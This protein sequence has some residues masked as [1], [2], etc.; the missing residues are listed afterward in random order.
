MCDP[1]GSILFVSDLYCGS[2]SDNDICVKSGFFE[3]LESLMQRGYLHPGDSIM[4]DKGF[5]I[6][7]KLAEIGLK[8][9]IPPFATSAHSMSAA[10]VTLTRKIAAHRIHV[11]RAIN[12]IKCFKLF[13][14]KIPVSLLH[15]I[16]EYWVCAS[17][18]TN[19]QDT[20]VKQP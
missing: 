7:D 19:F 10:N 8:L 11:E 2:I 17:L 12:Q 13:S 1:R 5:R 15:T 18:L 4:A 16:N 9:N 3:Y 14:R 20:L 6:E